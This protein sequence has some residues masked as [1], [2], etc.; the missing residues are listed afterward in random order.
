MRIFFISVAVALLFMGSTGAFAQAGM[1]DSQ[2]IQYVQDGLKQGKSQQQL[3]MELSAKGVTTEQALRLKQKYENGE[4]SAET[5]QKPTVTDTSRARDNAEAE[6]K[7][8]E[9]AKQENIPAQAP[10][11]KNMADMVFGRNIFTND[12]L[13]FEPNTNVATPENYRLGSGDEIIIDIWGAS[14]DIIR[15]EISPEG[16]INVPGLGIISLNGMNIADAKVYL[17]SELSRIYAD[18]GN[19]IQVTL[20]TWVA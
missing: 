5:E 18:E 6:K 3:M 20:L 17:K 15:K 8:E 4:I 1:T 19:K 12:K 11:E 9:A 16:T 2:V 13:S 7:A 14:E 10:A